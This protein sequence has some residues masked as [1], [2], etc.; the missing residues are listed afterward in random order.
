[1][2]LIGAGVGACTNEKS[3][4]CASSHE[5]EKIGGGPLASMAQYLFLS[6]DLPLLMYIT[7][8]GAN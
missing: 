2:V 1:M 3:A 7:P 4:F 5:F 6:L 8:Q